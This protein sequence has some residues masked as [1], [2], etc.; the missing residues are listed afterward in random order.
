MLTTGR[1]G[2]LFLVHCKVTAPA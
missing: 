2:G 1:L